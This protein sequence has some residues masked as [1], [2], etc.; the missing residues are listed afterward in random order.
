M[1]CGPIDRPVNGMI[2]KTTGTTYGHIYEFTCD[3]ENGYVLIG[4]AKRECLA[5]KRWSGSQPMC[6]CMYLMMNNSVSQSVSQSV[7]RSVS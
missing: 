7:S 2:L 1:D 6:K 3:Q 5:N 4:S